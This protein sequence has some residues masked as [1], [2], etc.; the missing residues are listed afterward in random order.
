MCF[1]FVALSSDNKMVLTWGRDALL[2][3]W[4]INALNKHTVGD[5]SPKRI[6]YITF[7]N[8]DSKTFFTRGW[9]NDVNVWDSTY[10]NKIVTLKGH[11]IMLHAWTIAQ[12]SV[13]LGSERKE[14]NLI[15]LETGWIWCIRDRWLVRQLTV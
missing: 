4:T 14:G 12:N 11:T 6:S 10:I 5:A 7:G 8:V 2:K 13:I 9:D 1:L 3:L 15:L